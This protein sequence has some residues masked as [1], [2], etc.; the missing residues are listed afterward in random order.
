MSGV[1]VGVV[2]PKETKSNP[3][4]RQKVRILS[5]SV[6]NFNLKRKLKQEEI[7]NV[8]KQKINVEDAIN[9]LSKSLKCETLTADKEQDLD[10]LQW[11]L[12]WL[13]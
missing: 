6:V 12:P 3:F 13:T 2:S 8:K 10:R 9:A 11:L 5:E 1:I 4:A 7:Q